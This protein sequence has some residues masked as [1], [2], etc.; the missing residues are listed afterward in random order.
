[1]GLVR[2]TTSTPARRA[3]VHE[4]GRIPTEGGDFDIYRSN[5]QIADMNALAATLAVMRW[6]RLR[7]FYLDLE[8]EYHAT[9]AVDGNHMI[10]KN[11][12]DATS[13]V[14]GLVDPVRDPV[15]P[16]RDARKQACKL[17]AAQARLEAGAQQPAF[18]PRRP[19]VSGGAIASAQVAHER[20]MGA[21][22][23]QHAHH[24]DDAGDASAS[25]RDR[26]RQA[27]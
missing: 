14:I 13:W 18:T 21:T 3:H 20:L 26:Q 6:K 10:N 11:H 7:G 2:I 23:G 22:A 12:R 8:G 1:M 25:S 19:P 9:Y 15:R 4:K 17:G 16:D 27:A 5:I 24:A